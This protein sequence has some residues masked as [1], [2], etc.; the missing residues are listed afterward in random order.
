MQSICLDEIVDFVI[1]N[2]PQYIGQEND[3][4]EAILKHLKYATCDFEVDGN[5]LTYFIR[6]NIDDKNTC[7]VLD[8]CIREDK[9]K[10]KMMEHI[11]RKNH[12]RWPNVEFLEYERAMFNK[13]LAKHPIGKFKGE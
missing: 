2:M 4:K 1:K 5:G 6:F 12:P 9:K 3:L 7:K 13:P 8:L 11:I 10:K